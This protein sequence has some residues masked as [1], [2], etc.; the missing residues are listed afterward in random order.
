LNESNAWTETTEK[1]F[2]IKLA[3]FIW[4]TCFLC[5]FELE[6]LSGNTSDTELCLSD[7]RK[8]LGGE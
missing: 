1:T 4:T 7:F 2:K 5:G 6:L 3:E 8:T